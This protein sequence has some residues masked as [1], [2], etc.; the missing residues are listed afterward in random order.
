[1]FCAICNSVIENAIINVETDI[2]IISL[3]EIIKLR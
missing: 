3:F 2:A 1:L